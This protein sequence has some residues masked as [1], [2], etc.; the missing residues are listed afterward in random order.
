MSQELLTRF[1]QAGAQGDFAAMQ[2]LLS[3]DVKLR[4]AIP[5]G[6]RQARGWAEAEPALRA[7]FPA[8]ERI[9][10]VALL[11]IQPMGDRWKLRYR[12]RGEQPDYG[13]FEYEQHAYARTAGDR[14]SELRILC[15]GFYPPGSAA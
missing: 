13:A 7:L 9:S 2:A 4:F 1:V 15:S 10:E 5:P 14:I 6:A 11:E 12:M 3:P 8:D